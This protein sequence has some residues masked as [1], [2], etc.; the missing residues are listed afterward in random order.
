MAE[1]KKKWQLKQAKYYR[2]IKIKNR[3]NSL[4]NKKINN[5]YLFILCPPFGGSTVLHEFLST[6]V[7]ISINN[8][9]GTREGQT[10]PGV[11]KIMWDPK[12]RWFEETKFDWKFI[13]KEWR[14]YWD[15]TKPLLL[16]KSPANIVRAKEIELEFTPSKFIVM[17]RNPYA[18]VEGIM[19]RNN[20]KAKGAATFAM[21][22]LYYQKNNLENLRNTLLFTYEDFCDNTVDIKKKIINFLPKLSDIDPRIKSHAHNFKGKPLEITNMNHEKISKLSNLD[23]KDINNVF[24]KNKDLINYFG[25]KLIDI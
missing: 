3:L 1:K 21:K 20:S 13:K 2:R 19:R 18:H 5:T 6:S 4:V 17:V 23:L 8:P 12:D 25:Y 11:K 10:L 22:C 14:K 9:F 15:V 24:K 7:N 16:E